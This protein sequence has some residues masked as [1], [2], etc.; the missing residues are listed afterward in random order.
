MPPAHSRLECPLSA[1]LAGGGFWALD[2]DSASPALVIRVRGIDGRCH[3]VAVHI[4]TERLVIRP[5]RDEEAPRLLDIL[6]RLE[7]VKWLGDGEPVLMADLDAARARIERYRTQSAEPPLG[8]WAVEVRETG[9]VAGTVLLT[10]L[11]NGDG[12]VEVGW[13]LH[14]DSWGHGYATEAA[15]AVIEHGFSAGLDEIYAITHTTNGPSQ[16]VCRRLGMDDLGVMEKWYEGP[17]RVFR[18]SRQ[19]RET[20]P[21]LRVDVLPMGE[22]HEG[23]EVHMDT[24]FATYLDHVRAHRAEL[25]ESVAAVDEALA[26]PIARGADWSGRLCAALAE[27][28]HDFGA[29]VD[30]TEGPGGLYERIKNAAPRLS[31]TIDRLSEEHARLNQSIDGFIAALED[32]SVPDDLAAFREDVTTLIGRLVRHRQ[33]GADLIYEAYEVDLGGSG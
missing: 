14:P 9:G 7:V 19:S 31:T 17:S 25:R 4:E 30:L 6:S 18:V 24:D 27:L 21:R 20:R 16:A 29:H 26:H 23:T 15:A 13:H 10:T 11:P 32:G 1:G 5:W 3:A 33:K 22:D 28:D 8:F 2:C 12:E